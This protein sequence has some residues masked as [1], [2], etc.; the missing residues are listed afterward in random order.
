[1]VPYMNFCATCATVLKGRNFLARALH[2]ENL[3]KKGV[4][5]RFYVLESE[6]RLVWNGQME[7]SN[8]ADLVIHPRR[9]GVVTA[10]NQ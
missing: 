8:R 2:P 1:M 5:H 7:K 9:S 3:N 10:L 4:D 6:H